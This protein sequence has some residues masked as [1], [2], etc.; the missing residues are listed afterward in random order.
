MLLVFLGIAVFSILLVIK[1]GASI[2]HFKQN[3]NLEEV[4]AHDGQAYRYP[5]NLNPLI[6]PAGGGLLYEDGRLLERT[7]TAEVVEKGSGKYS[8]VD[9][10]DGSY[11]LNFS[12]S[13]NSPPLTNGKDYTL[14]VK[15]VFLSRT[16]GITMLGIMI[17]G[18]AWFLT[19][20]LKSPANRQALKASP[21]TIW[22]VLDDFLV[23]EVPRI[24][25]PIKNTETISNFR[26]RLWIGLLTFSAGAAY[27]YV[28]M[29]WFFFV[30]KPSFMDLMSWVDKVEVFF[31]SSF[32][33]A[34]LS[35]ALV[36]VLVGFDYLLSYIRFST[37]PIFLGT[38]I[39]SFILAAISL[40][41]VDNF[42]YTIFNFGIVT[43]FGI[44]RYTYGLGFFIL[45]AYINSRILQ[46][47]GLRGK[48][49]PPLKISRY[50][51]ALVAGLLTI[52]A[53]FALTRY[54]ASASENVQAVN[55]VEGNNQVA[56]HP[57]IL[58]IGSDGLNASNL[59]AYGYDRD[60]TPVMSELAKTSLL[61]ENV[62]ANASNSAG[63]I[64]SILTGKPPAQ[65]RVLFPPNILQ[66]ANTYQHL[67]G[68]LRDEGYHTV[69]IGVPHY[70]DAYKVNLLDGF[71]IVNERSIEE[72]KGAQLARELGFGVSAYF[73]SG[74]VER[75]T[76][77][78]M[79]IFSIR[80]MENPFLIVTQP[81][82]TTYDQVRQNQL[83]ELIQSSERPL[84]IHVHMMGTHGSIFSPVEQ[85]FS[86]GKT[87]DEEWMIDFYDDSIL[88]FDHYIGE[89][90]ETLEETN[91]INNTILIIYSD[92]AMG[93]EARFRVP[94]LMH[95]PNGMFSGRIK[96][97]VQNMDIAPTILD[98]LGTNQ[99]TW[100]AGQSL[101]G[102]DPAENRLIISSGTSFTSA[103]DRGMWL[104]DSTQIKPPFYQFSF[105]NIINCQRWYQLDLANLTWNSGDIPGHTNP[106]TE[107][108]LL[109][110]DQIKEALT[111]YLSTNGFDISTLP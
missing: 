33:L 50:V 93:Y 24:F 4:K 109:S 47:L 10:E 35:L 59:S 15:V 26:R 5:I 86:I 17:L 52:S 54:S 91:K 111:E 18:L 99:P 51:L 55:P 76:D 88:T 8:L 92:H 104:I 87:Q 23:Q 82:E 13:D 44:W 65:T 30:T 31:L 90:L 28:F 75:I 98:Y 27:F 11:F 100:M 41:L 66:G 74:L 14:Y 22:Q 70:V 49:K 9:Q 45:F 97:N 25:P 20:A 36:M 58:I 103:V 81:V 79:H 60:T 48:P 83:L 108:S 6:F 110:M 67:P 101:L 46:T 38:L 84:F 77:R 89:I 96:T 64:T 12:A 57:N 3:V 69:E 37:E 80:E 71:D 105:F 43:S 61:A 19:F 42:T 85:K 40:L 7:Y 16:M 94:L 34:L 32:T 29:E 1:P 78:L 107:D 102:D 73:A 106:C 63:S 2:F 39:P 95:F 53:G 72:A 56:T 21:S 68:I 62:F